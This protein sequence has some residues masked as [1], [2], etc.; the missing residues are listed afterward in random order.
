MN[1]DNESFI[2][3][4]QEPCS[5]NSKLICQ[6]NSVQRFGKRVCPG[7]CIYVDVKSNAWYIEAISTKD[8]T[9][10]QISILRQQVL[11]VSAYLDSTDTTVW[12]VDMESVIE[13][14]DKNSLGL[15]ICV[16]SNSHS[17]LFGPDTN[18]RGRKLEDAI[19]GHNLCVENVGHI[20]TFHGGKARTCIDV[21]LSKRLHSTITGWRVNTSY[22][23]SHH[24][25]IEF[26]AE[27]DNTVIPRVWV[28]HKANWEL[29]RGK[30]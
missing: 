28:W 29:F 6:P 13:Y 9:T 22:N 11:V 17:T 20:P 3:C 12:T 18:T 21:T 27:Q 25:T 7:T 23:G 30:N 26:S 14:A 16:D 24:N 1:R 19:A 2:C 5:L 4:I 10:V 15:I 8:I